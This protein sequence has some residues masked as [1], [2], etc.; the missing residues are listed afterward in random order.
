MAWCH[1]ASLLAHA[2]D[3]LRPRWWTWRI[4]FATGRWR[5][6]IHRARGRQAATPAYTQVIPQNS[7]SRSRC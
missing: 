6:A 1:R 2:L 3:T 5:G 4:Y 7:A